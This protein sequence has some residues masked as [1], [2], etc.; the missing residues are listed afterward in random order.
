MLTIDVKH[1]PQRLIVLCMLVLQV[2]L[3]D[4]LRC[5]F[6]SDCAFP[7]RWS[8]I[9]VFVAR[10]SDLW[11]VA[12]SDARPP[13]TPRDCTPS[14]PSDIAMA[15]AFHSSELQWQLLRTG[16]SFLVKRSGHTFSSEPLNLTNQH[17]FKFSGLGMRQRH[18]RTINAWSAQ[19][20][21]RARRSPAARDGAA[22][23]IR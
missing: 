1:V 7:S 21:R 14:L 6:S 12:P 17:S 5:A 16:H 8:A 15:A 13:Y 9:D 19:M 10:L 3:F 4:V 23:R 11:L 22:R 18:R 20:H 2:C